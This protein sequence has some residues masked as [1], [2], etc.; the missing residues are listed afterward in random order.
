MGDPVAVLNVLNTGDRIMLAMRID[1]D[2][3]STDTKRLKVSVNAFD[4]RDHQVHAGVRSSTKPSFRASNDLKDISGVF[5][6]CRVNVTGTCIHGIQRVAFALSDFNCATLAIFNERN[7]ESGCGRQ[8]R[9]LHLLSLEGS[10]SPSI[11]EKIVLAHLSNS[12]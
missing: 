10:E 7:I 11:T 4:N 8:V 9:E 2:Q 12:H 3:E 6:R 1:L 5:R